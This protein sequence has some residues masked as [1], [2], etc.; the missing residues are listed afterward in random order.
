MTKIICHACGYENNI[1]APFKESPIIIDNKFLC[2]KCGNILE[3]PKNEIRNIKQ[4]EIRD[5]SIKNLYNSFNIVMKKTQFPLAFTII[6]CMHICLYFLNF[7]PASYFKSVVAAYIGFL[8]FFF[9]LNIFFRNMSETVDVIYTGE[10]ISKAPR[11]KIN[12]EKKLINA[13]NTQKG[14]GL[15]LFGLILSLFL[16]VINSLINVEFGL[17]YVSWLTYAFYGFGL[18]FC[19]TGRNE[20][21]FRHETMIY[22]SIA[23]FVIGIL[24]TTVGVYHVYKATEEVEDDSMFPSFF[25]GLNYNEVANKIKIG[26]KC[27]AIGSILFTIGTCTLVYKLSDKNGQIIIAFAVIL[28]IVVP[29]LVL[30]NME[31]TFNSLIEDIAVSKSQTE[32]KNSLEEYG[33]EGYLFSGLRL[34]KLTG[35]ILFIIGYAF[36][37]INM[38]EIK[39]TPDIN[40]SGVFHQMKYHQID[41]NFKSPKTIDPN[42]LVPKEFDISQSKWCPNCYFPLTYNPEDDNWYCGNCKKYY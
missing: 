27:A 2:Q 20:I 7:L 26:F 40:E 10:Q 23:L 11:W 31:P 39:A 13:V 16:S 42:L 32:F 24:F 1:G 14:I 21:G 33:T 6:I 19:Y 18:Y 4:Y 5:K 41:T 3:I 28:S 36:A 17:H 25:T 29:F 37:F 22:I 38:L 15:I 8:I 12:K 35:S 30:V 9:T 34:L